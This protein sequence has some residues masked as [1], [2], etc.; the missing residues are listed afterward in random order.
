MW[1]KWFLSVVLDECL[2]GRQRKKWKDSELSLCSRDDGK[3]LEMVR[4]H[5]KWWILAMIC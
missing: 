2:L 3:W 5:V 4:D 1:R